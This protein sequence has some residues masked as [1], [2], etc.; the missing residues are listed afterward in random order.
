MDHNREIDPELMERLLQL[1]TVPGRN[2]QHAAKGRAQFMQEV[3]QIVAQGVSLR[4]NNRHNMWKDTIQSI[5]AIKRKEQSHMFGIMT[6]LLLILGMVLGGGGVTVAAAQSS[7]PD[8][9]LYPVKVWSENVRASLVTDPE[10]QFDLALQFASRRAVEIQSMAKADKV[11]P[12]SVM[13]Q[14]QNQLELALQIAAN[15]P[16][17]IGDQLLERARDRLRQQDQLMQQLETQANPEAEAA[18]K[19]VRQMI[20]ERLS[21]VEDGLADPNRLQDR[22][23]LKDGISQITPE[24]TPEETL[25]GQGSTP[26]TA[27]ENGNPW[28]DETP[29]PGSG[30]GPGPGPDAT[31]TC[32]PGSSAGPMKTPQPGGPNKDPGPGGNGNDGGNGGKP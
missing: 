16:P 21:W 32:T 11:A 29:V 22:L 18:L 13:N 2:P 5:F 20:Q 14:M 12:E 23:R 19:R 31:C 1:K 25:P 17:G 8:Q 26:T 9:A 7:L 24:V 6:T 28:T 30:Y 10:A 27:G 3:Q 15:Q 4:E